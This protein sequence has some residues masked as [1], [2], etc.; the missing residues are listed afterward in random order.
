MIRI[1]IT[2]PNLSTLGGVSNFWNSLFEAFRQNDNID[3]QPLQ[4]GGHGKNPI[5]VVADQWNFHKALK[6]NIDLA[7]LNPSLIIKSF[8]RDGLFAKQLIRNRTPFVVF[9]HGWE[10]EFQESVDKKYKK[11]FLNSFAHAK[12]IFVL[13]HEF[14][15]K[16]LE[17]GY[18]GEVVVETTTVDVSLV[19]NF[20]LERKIRIREEDEVVKLLFVSRIIR[21]KGIFELVEAFER[22]S[23]KRG[24]LELTIAGD[25]EDFQELKELVASK[26]GIKLT[27]YVQGEEKIALFEQSDIYCLP[28]YTEGLPI[29][30]L[31][32]MLFGLPIIT[33]R[34]GGLKGFFGDGDMGYLIEPKN[35]DEIEEKI[36]K[37]IGDR[38]TMTKIGR[39]NYEYAKKHLTN[40]V[41]SK[42][43]YRHLKEV[44]ELRKKEIIEKYLLQED[45]LTYDPYDIWIT[46]FGKKVK[47]F[48]YKHRFMGVIPAGVLT[49]YDL[50]L[51][52][53][54]RL[55]YHK[56][57]YPIAKAQAV[58]AL[59]NLY[60]DN[61]DDIYLQ[62]AKKDIDW[63]VV[64]SS[65]GYSGCCWGLNFEWVYS[66]E[67]S[68][69]S[70]TPFSTHTPY[71]LE[72]MVK[73]Y[74]IT[75]DK[76]LIEPII[77][78]FLF[79]EN[80]IK[81]MIESTDKIILSYG[82][83]RDRIVVNAN[84]YA[85]Y[86]YALLLE[87]LPDKKEYITQ[88]IYK[89]YSFISSV[90]RGDGSWLYSP[91]EESTFIDCFHSAFV[92]KNL[93]KTDEIIKLNGVKQII[94]NGYKY[95]I[96]NFLDEKK[97]LFRR[98]SKTNKIS[99]VKFDLYDNAEMLNLAIMVDDRTTVERLSQSIRDNFI[100]KGDIASMIDI[101][102][103]LKNFN[104]LRWAVVPYIF[105][106]SNLKGRQ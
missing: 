58:L 50:Y 59:L 5:G 100:K 78:V 40:S 1:L 71:P 20:S 45:L 90:Q 99:I 77:S 33:T 74:E 91:Y 36:E 93:I 103:N 21:E 56:Q 24:N 32:A 80:D 22:S 105:A 46:D 27:G 96:D 16:I 86:C 48:Y 39:F 66:A 85:M 81:I 41:V 44:S 101:F 72:A 13:S 97:Y 9:F 53:T 94:K 38:E 104:H 84:S 76:S 102:G 25:G 49:I 18:Q 10:L 75:K 14:R 11:F 15:E 92:I 65:K 70:N 35:I 28:S 51:N 6:S 60:R 88:K 17:W 64:N 43:L 37:M 52:N 57:E 83:E 31:E 98:F 82:V 47:E 95:I 68:Y 62:Y 30:V 2:V 73:Y 26:K 4:I 69:D 55:G 7:F 34:V 63:L 61:P 12:K 106:L 79:F 67:D 19:D 8:F 42:R 29:A 89:L 87:F 3:F 23:K 54:L